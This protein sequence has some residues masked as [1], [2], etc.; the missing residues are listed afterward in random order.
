MKQP[1]PSDQ[2]PDS[3]G[4]WNCPSEWF[5]YHCLSCKYS[6]WV[7]DIIV[8]AFPPARGTRFPVIEC[9]KCGNDFACNTDRQPVSSYKQPDAPNF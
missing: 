7:E 9:P 4:P 1:L 3:D 8:D 2:P 6:T 5:S